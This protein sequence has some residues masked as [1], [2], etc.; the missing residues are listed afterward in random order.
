VD[1]HFVPG[2]HYALVEHVV[3]GTY[4]AVEDDFAD[5]VAAAVTAVI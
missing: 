4:N 3:A 2:S 5:P 1:E